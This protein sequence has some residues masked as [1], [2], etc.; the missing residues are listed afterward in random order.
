VSCSHGN[1]PFLQE[2]RMPPAASNQGW[3]HHIPKFGKVGLDEAAWQGTCRHA[4][5]VRPLAEVQVVTA[6]VRCGPL[7]PV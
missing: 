3:A 4:T 2:R 1:G 7:G 5:V 6:A